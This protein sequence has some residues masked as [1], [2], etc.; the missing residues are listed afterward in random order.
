[1]DS[2]KHYIQKLES[3]GYPNM[4]LIYPTDGQLDWRQ[5]IH[6]QNL[7]NV[8]DSDNPFRIVHK[9]VPAEPEHLR[10]FGIDPDALP[11]AG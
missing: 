4:Q 11:G 10:H 3:S 5:M 7:Q 1:M 2:F 9:D 6:T 8:V